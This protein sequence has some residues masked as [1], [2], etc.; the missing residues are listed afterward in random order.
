MPAI[1]DHEMSAKE[2]RISKNTRQKL[3]DELAVLAAKRTKLSASDALASAEKVLAEFESA[4]SNAVTA[5]VTGGCGPVRPVPD[6]TKHAE[7]MTAVT[8][9]RRSSATLRPST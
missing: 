4:E 1:E 9:A 7:L 5:W 6:T 3:R 8:A 2:L